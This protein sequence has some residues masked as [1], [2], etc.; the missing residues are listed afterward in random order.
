MSVADFD[1]QISYFSRNFNIL[2]LEE[3]TSI[4]RGES[5]CPS[6]KSILITFDDGYENNFIHAY[7]VL[8]KHNASAVIFPVMGLT[9]SD[10]PS[11]YDAIDIT[12]T[13]LAETK[14]AEQTS[15]LAA[16][17]G[18]SFNSLADLHVLTE[19]L[20]NLEPAQ[21]HDFIEKYLDI[22]GRDFQKD[23]S[24]FEFWKML[25]ESQIKQMSDEGLV[26]FGSHTVTHPNLDR[27]P[28]Q[29]AIQEIQQSKSRLENITGKPVKSIAFPDG[30]YNDEI[31]KQVLESGYEIMFS[32][33]TKCLSDREDK[34]IF[35][36]FSVPNTTTTDSVVFNASVAFANQGVL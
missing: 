31:K 12:K 5:N 25:S 18:I 15:S 32:V 35:R 4:S 22:A 1:K 7:P 2:S 14:K 34:T 11:W 16:E 28:I 20:K 29:T 23:D 30:G 13:S 19:G 24:K 10:M 17:F 27:I 6:G 9:G 21:K 36:R 8:K 3:F 33:T 26:A